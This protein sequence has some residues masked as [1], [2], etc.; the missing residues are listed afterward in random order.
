MAAKGSSTF[1]NPQ[2]HN[3]RL[4]WLAEAL[5]YDGDDCVIYPFVPCQNGYG[6]IIVEGRTEYTH[7]FVCLRFKGQPPTRKHHAA[8]ECGNKLC[9]N[10]RH[11]SWKTNSEN[12]LDRPG[13]GTA[14]VRRY[15][16]T[17]EQVAKI[18]A[19]EE[20]TAILAKQYGV[21]EVSIR[22][23]RAGKTWKKT[24][25]IFSPEE[26]RA[27]R[28]AQGPLRELAAQYRTTMMTISRIQRGLS[29]RHVA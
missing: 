25:R 28:S 20:K 27:I 23:I 18:R 26:V 6:S 19:S 1:E 7:R 17:P 8:H 2:P 21:N 3:K 9:V 15:I 4:I 10:P 16:L 11:I 5:K 22:Q 14:R 12:Q 29:Y 24:P 13:Q